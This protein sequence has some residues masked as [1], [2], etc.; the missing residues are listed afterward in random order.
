[1]FVYDFVTLD[2]P[3]SAVVR[4]LTSDPGSGAL[5][6][7]IEATSTLLASKNG[8]HRG[9]LEVGEARSFE[10]TV[11]LPIRWTP[12]AG[13]P[14]DRLDGFVQVAPFDPDG[15]HLSMSASCSEPRQGLGRRRD[16]QRTQRKTEAGVRALLHELARAIEQ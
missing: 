7:A 4:S 16:S 1:M 8:A 3:F 2:R 13:A 15:T 9:E 14:F 11:T 6:T 10:G 5:A 12:G